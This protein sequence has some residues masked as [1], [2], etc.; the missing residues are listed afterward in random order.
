VRAERQTLIR[1]PKTRAVVFA[2]HTD[3]VDIASLSAQELAGL[4]EARL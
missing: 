1:L 4:E 3:V 2:I